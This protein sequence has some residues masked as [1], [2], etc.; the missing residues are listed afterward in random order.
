MARKCI[1]SA[2]KEIGTTDI[3]YCVNDK[4]K[5]KYYKSEK[6]FNEYMKDQEYKRKTI[7]YFLS[8]LGYKYSNYLKKRLGEL[9]EHFTYEIIYLA[10]IKQTDKIKYVLNDKLKY[11]T[12]QQK[13]NYIIK[14]IE[15]IINDI[16]PFKQET[17]N[18]IETNID[19]LNNIKSKLIKRINIIQYL[20]K[21][22]L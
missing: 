14:I 9:N 8:L 20:D 13:I 1:C 4:G 11:S 5:N 18:S 7:E 19:E 10:F 16:K 2:T 21:E 22:D 15:S 12:E 17:E 6:I 3:F